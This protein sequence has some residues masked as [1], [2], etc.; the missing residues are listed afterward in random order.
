M[1]TF[2]VLITGI[3]AA[4]WFF[5]FF[6]TAQTSPPPTPGEE[7]DVLLTPPSPPEVVENVGEEES[8]F[9][10]LIKLVEAGVGNE[11]I[12]A[13]VR[14]REPQMKLTADQIVHLRDLGVADPMLAWMLQ[15]NQPPPTEPVAAAPAPVTPATPA[16]PAAPVPPAPPVPSPSV[17]IQVTTFTPEVAM[18]YDSLS[19]YG[20]WLIVDGRHCW[21]PT[22]VVTDRGWRP[23]VHRGR[24]V[25]T[26]YG[27]T[28]TSDYS[29]G[30]AAFHYGR[31]SFHHR[32][33][34]IWHPDSVWGPAWVQWRGDNMN[35]GWAPLPPSAH[36]Q[37]GIGF[38]WSNKHVSLDF[39]FGLTERDYYFVPVEHFCAPTLVSYGYGPTQVVNIYNRTTII[40]NKYVF[41]DK[42]V[43]N[44]G[45]AVDQVRKNS[46]H[47]VKVLRVAEADT[48][49]PKVSKKNAVEKDTLVVYRPSAPSDAEVAAAQRKAEEQ[50]R[51]AAKQA[52]QDARKTTKKDEEAATK[53][54][55]DAEQAERKQAETQR[56]TEQDT[57]KADETTERDAQRKVKA[58][59]EAASKAEKEAEQNARKQA[60]AQRKAEEEARRAAERAA[61]T[62]KSRKQAE[63]ERKAAEEAAR[64]QAEAERKAAK[65]AE[66]AARKQAEQQKKPEPAP[67]DKAAE[68]AE[69]ETKAA[70][71]AE[72][73]AAEEAAR[74]QSETDRKAAKQAEEAAR[75]QAEAERKAAKE[76][77]KEKKK[78]G[79]SE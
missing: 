39:H 54:T 75:K 28:W 19:P 37:T 44:S 56:K 31:W 57:K 22:V 70:A 14:G 11:V 51:K 27:W 6:E 42:T 24:W 32:H 72:R 49:D 3:A 33:G 62:D 47:E 63:A 61:T 8:D 18:F 69:R 2:T 48:R 43:V 29:W 76:A 74:R 17:T 67:R 23:Y 26:D 64:K 46:K 34:W 50:A 25:W 60:E 66:E 15:P 16:P 7:M 9:E 71:E 77:E 73:R 65:Q 52:E 55:K 4:V 79:E 30:W 20:T 21:R 36:Y 59:A 78:S 13:Y 38:F 45:V 35:C 68:Q 12:V 10:G 53:A 1:K 58:D 41:K 40:K 5:D